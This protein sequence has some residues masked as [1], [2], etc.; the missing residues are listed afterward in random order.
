MTS[1]PPTKE[2][3]AWGPRAPSQ[4]WDVVVIGAGIGGMTAAALLSQLGRK[5]LVLEQHLVP[6]GFSQSF[7]RA[8]WA[9]DVGLHVVGEMGRA[10]MVG[11]VIDRLSGGRVGWTRIAGAY[12]QIELPGGVHVEVPG[13]LPAF[14]ASLLR[15]FPAEHRGLARYFTLLREG[16]AGMRDSFVARTLM[17]WLRRTEG[18]ANRALALTTTADVLDSVTRDPLLRTALGAQWGFYGSVPARSSFGIHA[19]LA[20]HYRHG[21]W[22][23]VGGSMSLPRALSSSLADH[24]GWVQV[25]ADVEQITVEHGHATG[26][27]LASGE[28]LRAST[29]V[30]A[31]GALNTLRLL[32]PEERREEWVAPIEALPSSGAHVCLYVGFKGDIRKAGASQTN[33]WLIHSLVEELWDA[34][35]ERPVA[36]VSFPSLKDGVDHGPE[37][38]HTAEVV[39]IA[40]WD[41]FARFEGSRWRQRG[42]EYDRL[43]ARISAQL[44]ARLLER[45]PGLAPMVAF[46]ELSTPV[47]TAHFVRGVRGA[48][49]GLE[50]VRERFETRWLRPRTP[51]KGLHLAGC[52]VSVIGIAG[53]LV[54]GLAAAV[55]IAPAPA[56]DWLREAVRRPRRGQAMMQ[57]LSDSP[58]DRS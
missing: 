14:R 50:P 2:R 4:K 42:D 29:I 28:V 12:D 10:G 20:R 27:R 43:K 26:V 1:A 37:H 5:V 45:L 52:D 47:S 13:S 40:S 39:V 18:S 6:G 51:I 49:Y 22:Y 54:G 53:A 55:S 36:Y 35:T 57:P 24:G 32:P 7:R 23:P 31:A 58:T 44:L 30:S 16:A 46:T 33:H 25:S 48:A 56:G 15:S 34:Q 3:R 8:S 17:P 38:L 19:L 21:A 11:R 9:W 41:A